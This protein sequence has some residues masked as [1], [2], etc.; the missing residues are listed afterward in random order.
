MISQWNINK[1]D[2]TSSGQLLKASVHVSISNSVSYL[3]CYGMHAVSNCQSEG[4][5]VLVLMVQ[6]PS[7]AKDSRVDPHAES[8][9]FIPFCKSSKNIEKALDVIIIIT[10]INQ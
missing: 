4:V 7:E 2:L 6:P 1:I 9:S 8:S 10:I 3:R 5:M